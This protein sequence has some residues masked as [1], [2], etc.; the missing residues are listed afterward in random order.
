[1]YRD[2]YRHFQR[3]IEPFGA[4]LMIRLCFVPLKTDMSICVCRCWLKG[5]RSEADGSPVKK[6][7]RVSGHVRRMSTYKH[8]QHEGTLHEPFFMRT[9]FRTCSSCLACFMCDAYAQAYTH[10]Y[11][12]VVS[13]LLHM[14]CTQ[15]AHM[16]CAQRSRRRGLSSTSGQSMSITQL[17]STITT[18]RRV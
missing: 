6:A 15:Y 1:M 17:W 11:A 9:V 12:H 5:V 13:T 16:P 18:T 8:V 7:N 4:A 14:F 2:V 10:V 3:R